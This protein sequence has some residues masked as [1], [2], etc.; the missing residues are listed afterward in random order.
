M[1]RRGI[2]ILAVLALASVCGAANKNDVIARR[3]AAVET[4][5]DLTADLWHFWN[6]GGGYGT[7]DI[8]SKPQHVTYVNTVTESTNGWDFGTGTGYCNVNGPISNGSQMVFA[9]WAKPDVTAM[10]SHAAGGWLFSDRANSAGTID[11]QVLYQASSG[12]YIASLYT[13]AS[14]NVDVP[15]AVA[16]NGVW[17]H[18]AFSVADGGQCVAFLNGYPV[19][20]STVLNIVNGSSVNATVAWASWTPRDGNTKYH[21]MLDKIRIYGV[22]KD[23]AF[24]KA[25]FDA[26][27]GSKGL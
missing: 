25:I 20:T 10:S 13:N 4:S 23:A 27:K 24:I 22:G 12:L 11:W 2:A 26:E 9:A 8:G 19:S 1:V 7:N 5:V 16:S 15:L 17:Q 6:P 21:G 18:I 14:S 3:S